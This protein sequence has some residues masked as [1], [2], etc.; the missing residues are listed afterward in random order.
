MRL[1]CFISTLILTAAPLSAGETPWQEVAPGVSVRL[2]S[3]G[4][5]SHS[6]KTL[7]AIEIDMPDD[8][9]TYW[10]VPGQAGLPTELDLDG[11]SGV[12]AHSLLWPY[13]VRHEQNGVLDYVYFG[14]TVLPIELT[15]AG[16]R[17]NLKLEATMGICSEICVPAQASF[18]LALADSA[19]DR[20][21]GLRI[22]QALAD[23]PLTWDSDEQPVGAVELAA[24]GD[25]ILVT[26]NADTVDPQSLIAATHSGLPLFGAPQKSPKPDLVLLPVLGKSTDLSLVDLDV[27]LIFMTD[28]GAFEVNR[29][30]GE[31]DAAAE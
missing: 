26:V 7:A 18:E 8:T 13:P 21:N 9:K 12:E 10:R 5:V 14:D 19:P 28:R 16:E 31:A 25:A 6:G 15:V 29:V 27:Q 4:T 2:I 23:V 1:F 24:S 22:K 11:S 30:I 20:P 17:A 3:S